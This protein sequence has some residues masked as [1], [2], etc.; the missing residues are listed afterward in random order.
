M[1]VNLH[2]ILTMK[3]NF[4]IFL[5][6]LILLTACK[7][8]DAQIPQKNSVHE[9]TVQHRIILYFAPEIS[10]YVE[11]I[12]DAT[13]DS[14]FSAVTD[15]FS[16]FKNHKLLTLNTSVSYENTSAE[17]IREMCKNN[18]AQFAVVPKIKFFKVGIGQFVFSSQVVVSMKLYDANGNIISE[19]TYDTFRKNAR[20][21]GSA[22]NSI[23][24]GTTGVLKNV[25]KDLKKQKIVQN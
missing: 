6:F 3:T 1:A 12:K 16:S 24:I 4:S 2:I 8:L 7:T 20:I 15:K 25:L 10:P 17:L 11:E 5:S 19:N 22:E 18:D 14:F 21:L 9:K 13:F 23:K